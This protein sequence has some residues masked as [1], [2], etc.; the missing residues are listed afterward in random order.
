MAPSDLQI[1]PATSTRA[2]VVLGTAVLI[3]VVFGWVAVRRQFGDMLAELTKTSD[4]AASDVASIAGSM[5]PGDPLTTWLK[6]TLEKNVFTPEKT[7][8]SIKLFED[9][10]RLSPR[11]FRW[12][13]ELGRAYEQDE[14]AEPAEAAFKQAVAL[15]P[16][17]SFPHW[18][19]GNFYLRQGRNDEAFAEFKTVSE[20]DQI[21][22]E[23]V[24][25]LAWDYFDK[26]PQKLETMVADRPDVHASLAMFYAQRGVAA[27][28][29][30]NWNK[31]SD[32]EKSH[33]PQIAR[34][35]TQGLYDRRFF[36]Q[37]LEFA[38]QIGIDPD[39]KPETVTN[40]GFERPLGNPD[41]T[42]FGW[43]VYHNEGKLDI[44]I[45]AAVH[46][47]GAKSARFVFKRYNKPT[48]Y[49]MS[50]N[51][52]VE[53]GKSYRLTFWVRTEN[54]LSGGMPQLQIANAV[55]DKL[56][57]TSPAFTSGTND[58]KLISIEFTAPSDC[59]GVVIWT[60]RGFC[61]EDCPIIGTMWLD[62][63]ELKRLN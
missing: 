17:Y 57:T 32:D 25:S 11:D 33:Y 53:P 13:I 12:W 63:F 44:G 24:F 29:L 34:A 39:A 15:A 8:S 30:R 2:R 27:D 1:V 46:H 28:S 59:T 52:V 22:R 3:A 6:G 26:D 31:L 47:E 49:A 14:R 20:S 58:W 40:P 55:D 42:K 43:R 41:D 54:L 48:L 21:Y 10:V 50:Q 56:I 5:A 4:P 62:E 51:I 45:D 9:T 60:G 19:L 16:T 37:A 36:P 38:R 35:I 61:G 23:Q 18:Q 7:N